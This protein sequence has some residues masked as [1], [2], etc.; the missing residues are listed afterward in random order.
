MTDADARP[1][2]TIAAA[3][4]GSN[5]VHLLVA[6]VGAT[7]LRVLADESAFLGLG[8]AADRGWLGPEVRV[9]LVETIRGQLATARSHGAEAIGL[10]GT[11]PLRRSADAARVV[12]EV[13][14]L[15]GVPFAVLSHIEEGLLTLL[16]VTG[17]RPPE[18][19]LVVVDVGGGSSQ[20]V[21][22][23]PGVAPVCVGL[24]LGSARLTAAIVRHDP[25]S[26]RE[27]SLL[28][29]R[30]RALVAG[31]PPGRPARL[32]FVGGRRRT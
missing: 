6:H 26:R 23:R 30:A 19:E 27:W 7:G 3:D 20:I 32:V 2:R 28:Q 15:S 22:A 24:P 5:S 10:V 16:G 1:E 9:Q 12:V 17:G 21:E 14:R 25:P 18:G 11:E 4:A 13:E 29:E 8:E 31:A